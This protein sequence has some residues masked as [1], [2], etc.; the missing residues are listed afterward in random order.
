[1]VGNLG[2]GR[3]CKACDSKKLSEW[4]NC[5]VQLLMYQNPS[6][7]FKMATKK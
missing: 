2:K 3:I 6:Y 7:N 1:M 5:L 4:M